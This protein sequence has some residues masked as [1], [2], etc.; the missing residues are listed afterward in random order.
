MDERARVWSVVALGLLSA[1]LIYVLVRTPP[2]VR[3]SPPPQPH[4][5]AVPTSPEGPGPVEEN[6]DLYRGW[7]LFFGW[8]LPE[9]PSSDWGTGGS[10]ADSAPTPAPLTPGAPGPQ[11]AAKG[12][13]SR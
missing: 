9:V 10:G 5:Q 4:V 7:P 6:P 11:G 13:S 2:A 8:P 3:T 1:I 12:D